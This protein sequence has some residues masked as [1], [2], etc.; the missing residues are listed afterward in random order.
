M[1]RIFNYIFYI[2]SSSSLLF[3]LSDSRILTTWDMPS[4]YTLSTDYLNNS[5]SIIDS[6]VKYDITSG[7]AFS[8]EHKIINKEKFNFFLGSELMLGKKSDVSLAFHSIYF[9]PTYK[10]NESSDILFRLGYSSLNT[11]DNALPDSAH[12]IGLGYEINVSDMW[13]INF[14]NTFYKTNTKENS[15][16]VCPS[17]L[18]DCNE[19]SFFNEIE[20][21][22]FSIS[23][24]YKV[25]KKE[26]N[27]SSRRRGRNS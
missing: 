2:L 3:S 23:I 11:N 5:F 22:K 14:F 12:M 15:I 26:D 21:N 13:S 9:M 8:Y 7:V 4:Q 18:E 24:V 1:N 27:S 16:L 19:E 10:L 17:L 25:V 6:K 20:Y